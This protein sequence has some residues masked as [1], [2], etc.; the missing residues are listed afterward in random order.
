[1]SGRLD[2]IRSL[3]VKADVVADVGC[4]HGKIAEYCATCGL[5]GRVIASD[6]SDVCLDKA[7]KRLSGSGN[8]SFVCCDGLCYDCDE[9]VI[10]GM[11]GL[12]ISDILRAAHSLPQTLIVCPHRDEYTLRKTLISLGYGIDRDIPTADRGKY[13]SVIRAILGSGTTDLDE[14]RL[15]F[16]AYCDRPNAALATRLKKLYD[17]YMRAP[18]ANAARLEKVTAAMRLQGMSVFDI[19]SYNN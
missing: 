14:I 3:I 7:R 15:E 16:G 11:G 13:Y 19:K 4:D 18:T 12:L 10:A 9:A 2:V 17:V 5:C 1:M 6:V 8:V